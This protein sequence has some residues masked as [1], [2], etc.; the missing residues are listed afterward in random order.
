MSRLMQKLSSIKCVK[1]ERIRLNTSDRR[2]K[3]NNFKFKYKDKVHLG[4]SKRC[5]TPCSQY[6]RHRVHIFTRD[7]TGLVYLPNQLERTLQ[8]YW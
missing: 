8:L 5:S 6:C 2:L 7:E 4:L 3:E 1:E